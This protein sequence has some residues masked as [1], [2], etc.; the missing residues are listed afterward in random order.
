MITS[1][2]KSKRNQSKK[3]KL[4]FKP[5]SK[6]ASSEKKI[7]ENS[8]SITNEQ[9]APKKLDNISDRNEH[10][11]DNVIAKLT[12][13]EQKLTNDKNE[14][15]SDSIVSLDIRKELM[16]PI[17]ESKPFLEKAE[18]NQIENSS[19]A[20]STKLDVSKDQGEFCWTIQKIQKICFY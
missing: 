19:L 2:T 10:N 11:K 20:T 18:T 8:K 9:A 12:E 14:L 7:A 13:N 17:E 15:K 5:K 3:S 1:N 6:S 16:S 4:D